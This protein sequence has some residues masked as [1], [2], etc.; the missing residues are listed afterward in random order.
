MLIFLNLVSDFFIN[1]ILYYFVYEVKM[2]MAYLRSNNKA[3]YQKYS[4]QVRIQR[5]MFL[6]I[7][8]VQMVLSG[9]LHIRKSI[10]R[11]NEL[12]ADNTNKFP[13][14]CYT[15]L[16]ALRLLMDI[17]I[18][19]QL[20]KLVAYFINLKIYVLKIQHRHFSNFNSAL[21]FWTYLLIFVNG[22]NKWLRWSLNIY[23]VWFVKQSG[24]EVIQDDNMQFFFDV[25]SYL[26]DPILYSLIGTTLLYLFYLQ[27]KVNFKT[28]KGK[29]NVGGARNF[30]MTRQNRDTNSIKKM[31]FTPTTSR[32]TSNAGATEV[33][34]SEHSLRKN[35]SV[36]RLVTDID[37][38]P[39]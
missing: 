16:K 35:S 22:V 38:S 26:I 8:T 21:A 32:K 15:L 2:I 24:H 31:L 11:I 1:F 13:I 27:A 7:Y 9:V 37:Y 29:Q 19:I 36:K 30:I 3:E 20:F 25:Q 34:Y 33:N 6:F 23:Y 18:T 17:Y 4:Q 10:Y 5:N 28:S 39:P 14:I 12:Y